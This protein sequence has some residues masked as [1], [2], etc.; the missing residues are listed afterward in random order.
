MP[1][2]RTTLPSRL[3][4]GSVALV[5]RFRRGSVALAHESVNGKMRQPRISRE[6]LA[7]VLEIIAG[8]KTKR[9]SEKALFKTVRHRPDRSSLFHWL[10]ANHDRL[11]AESDGCR[12]SWLKL[13]ERF[14]EMGL[15]D[16]QGRSPSVATARK[17]WERVRQAVAAKRHR[18]A[19]YNAT[20][21]SPRSLMPSATRRERQP[22][23]TG[24]QTGRTAPASQPPSPS[25]STNAPGEPVQG[26]TSQSV[27][28][29]GKEKI[30]RLRRTLEER[31][32][33]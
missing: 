22:I 11:L 24:H 6:A 32:G 30:A 14:A 2:F 12:L 23:E 15:T 25:S 17:T 31:S 7:S 3:C 19:V 4:R 27:R 33:R 26:E 9:P 28:L 13:C 10:A 20:G 1:P 29:T 21:L 18:A 8:M 16:Q 5:S